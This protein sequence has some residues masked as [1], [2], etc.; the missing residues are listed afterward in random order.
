VTDTVRSLP[1]LIAEHDT[2]IS[3]DP[4]TGCPADCGYCYLGTLGLRATRPVSR[5]TP[6]RMAEEVH[7]FLH[8]RRAELIDP[9]EDS[10]PLCLGNHTDMLMSPENRKT[11][12][13]V[14][15]ELSR[16]IQPRV[17]VLITKSVL[18]EDVVAQIDDLDWPVVWFFSQSFA[19]DA[20]IPL[21]SGRVAH[22]EATL[23][24]ARMVSASR[25]QQ[26]VHFWRPFVR[27]LQ[28]K[29]T[30]KTSLIESLKAAGMRCSVL[31]G[32]QL[33]PGVPVDDPRLHAHL[34]VAMQDGQETTQTFDQE[35]WEETVRVGRQA[36]YPI[37]RHSSCALALINSAREQLG[38]WNRAVFADRCA[39]CF[40]PAEQRRRCRHC[41][42][43]EGNRQYNPTEFCEKLA[44]FLKIDGDRISVNEIKKYIYIDAAVS[45]FDYNAMMHA[46]RGRYV[47]V[48]QSTTLHRAWQSVWPVEAKRHVD[49]DPAVPSRGVMP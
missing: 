7:D 31:T 3:L 48:V 1:P 13:A 26:A 46:V 36:G 29:F 37:Y 9:A 12:V 25:N 2:W 11:T 4:V 15:R 14:L 27:E 28:P 10:T 35:G 32:L 6:R 44:R 43:T 22:F 5:I 30:D 41:A 8:G 45:E 49:D 20:G 34:P 18:N 24:N 42:P 16:T 21:E 38:T 17:T 47:M 33:G 19:R 23:V 40:C 39:P